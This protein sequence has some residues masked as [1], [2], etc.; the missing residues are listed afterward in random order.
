MISK[1]RK[2][3]KRELAPVF[4]KVII[5]HLGELTRDTRTVGDMIKYRIYYHNSTTFPADIIITDRLPDGLSHVTVFNNGK[6]DRTKRIVTWRVKKLSPMQGSYVEVQARIDSDGVISNQA[7]LDSFGAPQRKTNIVKTRVLVPPKLGWVP[8]TKD[9][10]PGEPAR[11]YMKDETTTG[12]T[13][14]FDINGMHVRKEILDGVAYH[15][16][17][18]PGRATMLEVGKPQ[19]PIVGQIIEV[20]HGVDIN[21]IIV[22]KEPITLEG[23]NVYPTQ[24]P[25]YLAASNVKRAFK[26]DKVTYLS[27][28]TYPSTPVA[29]QAKDIGVIRGHRLVFLKVCPL[30]YN[31]TTRKMTAFSNIE[32]RLEYDHPAQIEGVDRRIASAPFEALLQSS[33]INYKAPTRTYSCG[34]P[35]PEPS[36]LTG[37]HYL[38]L[39]HPDFYNKDPLVKFANW[40]RRKGLI[41]KVVDVSTIPGGNTADAIKTYIRNAYH[42]WYPAPAYVLLIGDSNYIPPNDGLPHPQHL[43]S[44]GNATPIATDIYYATVDGNDYFSDIFLGRWS[45]DNVAQLGHVVDKIIYYEN[46]EVQD[47]KFYHDTSLVTVFI[48]DNSDGKE[49]DGYYTIEFAEAI[50]TYLI[51]QGYDVQRIYCHSGSAPKGPLWYQDGTD[52]PDEL[53][54]PGFPWSGGTQDIIQAINT[55]NFLMTYKGHGKWFGWS[56]PWFMNGDSL[57]NVGKL[58]VIFSLACETGWFDNEIDR[59]IQQAPGANE[60]CF[61]ESLL[62]KEW[63][64][65]V[66]VIGATRDAPTPDEFMILGIYKAIWPDFNPTPPSVPLPPMDIAPLL[67][68]G[69]IL[70]FCKIYIANLLGP[71]TGMQSVQSLFELYNLFG[72][73]EMPIWT[74]A[75]VRLAVY[76]PESIGSTGK[77]DFMVSVTDPYSGT[78]VQG[79]TVTLTRTLTPVSGGSIPPEEIIQV[80]YTDPGGIALFAVDTI[81]DTEIQITASALNYLPYKDTIKVTAGGAVLNR[82]DPDNGAKGQPFLLGGQNFS[83]ENVDIYFEIS[84]QK[85]LVKTIEASGG[86]FGQVGADV[87]IEVPWSDPLGPANLIA[88]GQKSGRCAVRVFHV[89]SKKLVDLWIYSQWD[90]NTWILNSGD[91]NPIWNN[92]DIRLFEGNNE[93]DS[94]NLTVL[95]KYTVKAAI[96]NGTGVQADN[97]KVVFSWADFGIGG[98]WT[99]F[100]STGL[101][102]GPAGATAEAPFTPEA[103]GHICILVEIY[104]VEDISPSNNVGQENLHVGPTSSAAMVAFW[105]SNP[106]QNPAAVFIE[107]RQVFRPGQEGEKEKGPWVTK[108][109][110][111]DPQVIKPGDSA[112]AFLVVDPGK[113]ETETPAEFAITGFIEGKMIGGVNLT[114]TST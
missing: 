95:T 67:R 103:T 21:P 20:P 80:S 47:A 62:R 108:V 32:V 3:N 14:N 16:L 50:R 30:Q 46:E 76:H 34:I 75:P 41:T 36:E 92:P 15:H 85:I 44:N 79:A 6:Y 13:V 78:P 111:P 4:K 83:K 87:E 11:S 52:L 33:V 1:M 28:A 35:P 23:Y 97:A 59:G 101:D 66:A 39:T 73:P 63:A 5:S 10:K 72:D 49:D 112:R 7:F 19:L 69:Q 12:L 74:R 2:I 84:G 114:I 58:P 89:R 37:C 64:G 17:S 107:V 81:T 61:C 94:N 54:L 98:P 68:M 25:E 113:V 53:K 29:I 104:H 38:I 110:H 106:T 51:G 40:K 99:E 8:F 24:K 100:Y 70:N 65:A 96:H 55:G 18:I 93:V 27:A 86:D 109:M 43:D 45:V 90:P 31:F 105:V 71:G 9:S 42:T 56:S 82:L 102:V 77:Q 91:C 88:V 60:E 26:I 22:K 48:D 57:S